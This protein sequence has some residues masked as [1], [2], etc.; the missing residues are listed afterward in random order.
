[1]RP[2]A[3][4]AAEHATMTP[5][6]QARQQHRPPARSVR[7]GRPGSQ[8][9]E[10]LRRAGRRR[11]RV[12]S[13]ERAGRLPALRR[14]PG[15]RRR[16]GQAGRPHPHR[17]RNAVRQVPRR[18]ARQ[19]AAFRPAAAV[20]LRIDRDRDAV[21]E[22]PG[23]GRPQP[24]SLHVPP[25]RRADPP[26]HSGP[27]DAGAA[28][29]DAAA[30]HPDG[31]GA[32]RWRASATSK[33]RWPTTGRAPSSRWRRDRARRTRP[34]LPVTDSSGSPGRSASCSWWTATTWAS[35]RSTSS[36]STSARTT[37]GSSPR[38]TASST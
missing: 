30:Q 31:S 20:R 34:F 11:A 16:R 15:R 3:D 29:R 27:A 9:D 19:P 33:R 6:Q 18:P 2:K 22:R 25:A 28:A 35:K 4:C 17:R 7:L 23:A 26:G 24:G 14:L 1:M 13:Q 5:E 36:S 8:G 32:S 38:N 10:H 12:P 37:A 21:H